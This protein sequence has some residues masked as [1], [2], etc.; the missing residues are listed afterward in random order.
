[1][2]KIIILIL[3]I[4]LFS[5]FW[6]SDEVKQAKLDLLNN[7]WW[8]IENNSW[9]NVENNI[10][11]DEKLEDNNFEDIVDVKNTYNI[12]YLTDKFIEINTFS[13]IE[14]IKDELDI[15]WIV[16]NPDVDKIIVT[17]ENNTSNFPKDIYTLKTF[18][19]WNK[20]FLYRAHKKF[21]TLDYW[22]NKYTFDAY[23]WDNLITK[24]EIEVNLIDESKNTLK[25][26]EIKE[27][28]LEPLESNYWD[29][30]NFEIKKISFE[31]ELSCENIWDFLSKNYSWY[32]WNTCLPLWEDNLMIN[33]L[34]L[35]WENFN[36]EK[37]Y[38]NFKKWYLWNILLEKWDW[39]NKENIEEKNKEFKEKTFD[40]TTNTDKLFKD[41]I[42]TN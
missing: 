41:F 37:L 39:I 1:M 23:V 34:S 3:P 6:E 24:I 16:N 35:S 28:N 7:T 40:I 11:N 32:Y 5:C 27:N 17:F 30:E 31:T 21:Q 26:D 18:K 13:N 42:L 2:K 8:V 19:K 20:D 15:N 9:W 12:N 22:L 38:L 33:V 14:N 36:Y 4:F 25:N 29:I 10:T